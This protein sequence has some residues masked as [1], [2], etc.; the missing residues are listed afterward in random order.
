MKNFLSMAALVLMG[1]AM[2]GCINDDNFQQS[3]DKVL[4]LKT[5]ISLDNEGVATRALNVD[6]GEQK[7]TKIFAA[8]DQ[9]V[10]YYKDAGNYSRRVESEALTAPDISADGKTA[11]FTVSFTYTPGNNAELRY[12]YPLNMAG[13]SISTNTPIS[14]INTFDYS[15]LTNQTGDL[16]DLGS[17]LDLATFDG[18][19]SGTSLPASATLTNRLA[20]LALTLKNSAGSSIITSGLTNVHVIGTHS[21]VLAPKGGGTF[22]KDVIYAAIQPET[23]STA[24]YINADGGAYR[25]T[26]TSRTYLAGNFYNL[27]LSMAY[28][29]LTIT[30]PAEG[31]VIGSDGK[32]YTYNSSESNN[33]LPIGVTAVA[34]ICYVSGEHGMALAMADESSKMGWE[35]AKTT[36]AAHTPAF[37]GGT[38][39][40][41]TQN[42]WSNMITAAGSYTALRDGFESVGGTN[43][44]SEGY[45]SSTSYSN[46][47]AYRCYF[48]SG[49]WNTDIITSNLH[50]RSTLVF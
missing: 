13:V 32:N 17:K 4:T 8:G 5:T 49:N 21:C 22:G 31:Q 48:S 46:S 33:G 16:A 7:A 23:S 6:F 2:T 27:V 24:L 35:D 29:T 20:I 28:P 36:A 3:N 10:V 50:V 38:W 47:H 19:F 14:D 9:I 42:E 15:N 1:L 18:Y 39:K 11:N 12:V 30:S 44:V 40:L 26:L 34:K 25:K 41:A 45:W 37:T 43:M